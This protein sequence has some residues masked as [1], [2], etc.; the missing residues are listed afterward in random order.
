MLEKGKNNS[1]ENEKLNTSNI[2]DEFDVDD[3][4]RQEIEKIN[5]KKDPI[6]FISKIS[7]FMRT[8]NFL[9]FFIIIIV[10]SYIFVQKT[11]STFFEQKDYLAPFC[12]I[13]NWFDYQSWSTCSSLTISLNNINKKNKQLEKKYLLKIIPI[14]TKSYEIENIQNSQKA[15]FIINKSKNKNNPIN[16]LNEFDKLKNQ[17]RGIEKQKMTCNKINIHNDILEARCSTFSTAWHTGIPWLK[18][19]KSVDRIEG[20]SISLASSF[21]NFIDKNDT[22]S[23]MEEQKTFNRIPYFWEGNYIYKTDFR[24]KIKYIKSNLVLN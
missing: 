23:L 6:Y 24:L 12:T 14:I 5:I 7:S 19:E 8:L 10:L 11:E 17:F 18:W 20:T 22:F 1:E 4:T 16:I 13:L 9:L 15:L 2:F 21:L 3:E